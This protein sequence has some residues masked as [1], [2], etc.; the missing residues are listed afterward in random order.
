MDEHACRANCRCFA[1]GK[2]V[3]TDPDCS[4]RVWFIGRR[5][6][7]CM[8]CIEEEADISRGSTRWR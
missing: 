4:A 3:C 7:L 8:Q 6:R 1:C 2:A 5:S